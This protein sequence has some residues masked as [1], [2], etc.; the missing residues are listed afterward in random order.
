MDLKKS[1][2]YASNCGLLYQPLRTATDG[3]L[4]KQMVGEKDVLTEHAVSVVL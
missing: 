1:E 2:D 4:V 3:S